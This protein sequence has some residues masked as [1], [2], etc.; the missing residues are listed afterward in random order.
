MVEIGDFGDIFKYL[1]RVVIWGGGGRGGFGLE[2]GNEGMGIRN[3]DK[4]EIGICFIICEITVD[5]GI[6]FVTFED[7]G[8]NGY[9]VF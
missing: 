4:D 6:Y 9:D 5:I 1:K 3:D 2:E 8:F 7:E